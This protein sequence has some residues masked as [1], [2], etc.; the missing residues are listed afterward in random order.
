MKLRYASVIFTV[1]LVL[2]S[3]ILFSPEAQSTS[4]S[5]NI[6]IL[7]FDIN[8]DNDNLS[9]WCQDLSYLLKQTNTNSIVFVT[10]SLAEKH[11]ECIT[12]FQFLILEL[13]YQLLRF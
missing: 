3:V 13:Y 4:E 12:S 11:P 9:L 5:D 1:L 7:S 6:V 8:S 2:N 10:G